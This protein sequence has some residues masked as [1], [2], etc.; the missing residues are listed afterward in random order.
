MSL[1]LPF[2][3]ES[4]VNPTS[5]TATVA[6]VTTRNDTNNRAPILRR[7]R[8]TPVLPAALM[9]VLLRVIELPSAVL[10]LIGTYARNVSRLAHV[11]RQLL[12]LPGHDRLHAPD[13][14]QVSSGR[15]R[16]EQL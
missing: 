6:S 7:T 2:H 1:A 5:P 3:D 11:A 13:I 12:A 10:P 16:V 14:R 4:S 15:S 8:L 9:F